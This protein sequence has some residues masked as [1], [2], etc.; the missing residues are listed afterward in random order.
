MNVTWVMH[1]DMGSQSDIQSYVHGVKKTG[2]TVVEVKVCTV[3][4]RV[5]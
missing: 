2:A 5:A 3:F 1:T 4:R